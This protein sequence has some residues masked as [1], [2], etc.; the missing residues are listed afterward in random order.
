M[1]DEYYII[2]CGST[3]GLRHAI[4]QGTCP[5]CEIDGLRKDQRDW[6][7]G[8]ELIAS[9]LGDHEPKDLSCVRLSEV[10]LTMRADKER[11]DWLEAHGLFDTFL[12]GGKRVY[13]VSDEDHLEPP[14]NSL[15]EAIDLALE[16]GDASP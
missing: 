4:K 2:D 5:W 10:A 13:V 11:L 9:G 3:P 8:V 6:R 16:G 14:A 12:T 15:R 7:N 1:S